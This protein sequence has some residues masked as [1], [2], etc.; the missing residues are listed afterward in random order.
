MEN[1]I[2]IHG[3]RNMLS[4]MDAGRPAGE[5]PAI[6]ADAGANRCR[7]SEEEVFMMFEKEVQYHKEGNEEEIEGPCFPQKTRRTVQRSTIQECSSEW[8]LSNA[9]SAMGFRHGC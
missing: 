7:L 6:P 9:V 4:H 8:S 3:I 5:L 2:Q 1:S